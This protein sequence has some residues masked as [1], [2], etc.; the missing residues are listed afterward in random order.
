MNLDSFNATHVSPGQPLTAQ[1]WNDI[2]DAIDQAYKY[3]QATL[4]TVN[5]QLSNPELQSR[6]ML[7]TVRVFAV[8]AGS[9]PFE[10]V[11]P[12]ADGG[13]H[14]L[15][16]LTPGA[17][18][19]QAEAL[20][21]TPATTTVTVTGTGGS[22][23]TVSLALAAAGVFMPLLFGLPL[24]QAK[25]QL[26]ALQITLSRLLD[27][28]GNDKAPVGTDFDNTPVL[29]QSPLPGTFMKAGDN[30][31]LVVGVPQKVESGV[32]VPSLAGLT[33]TEAQKA[34]ESI[35]LVLGNVQIL[36]SKSKASPDK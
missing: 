35:G 16:G 7:E 25:A 28:N 8:Q 14:V 31:Q 32:L 18:T 1:A 2:V 4:H 26:G 13:A 36:Q 15:T 11:R 34:L 5:V 12:M 10:A 29:V 30:A 23:T 17:Y 3:L 20:G 9:P 19:I 6:A 24:G 21:Y 27:F 22:N 33:Q